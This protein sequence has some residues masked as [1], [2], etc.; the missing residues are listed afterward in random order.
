MEKANIDMF[1][2]TNKD[3]FVDE[4]IPMIRHSLESV[5]DK[6]W[7][8]LSTISFKDP[9]TALML[10]IFGGPIGVDRFYISDYM[11]GVLKTVTCGGILVWAFVDQFL[12]RKA[13]KEYN[14]KMLL[15][16]LYM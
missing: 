12:I 13:T 5:D 15:N 1:I 14:K 16:I 3:F 11:L 6:K 7:S 4:D 9:M 2:L 8:E 10:S